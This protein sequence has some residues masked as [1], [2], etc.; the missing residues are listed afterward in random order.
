MC[1]YESSGGGGGS[2]R[3]ALRTK[4]DAGCSGR[5]LGGRGRRELGRRDLR[6][7]ERVQGDVRG[8]KRPPHY[9]LYDV[10]SGGGDWRKAIVQNAEGIMVRKADGTVK[11]YQTAAASWHRG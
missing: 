8:P 11:Y 5:M 3:S 4:V 9:G 10:E 2:V 6:R 1:W 7:L